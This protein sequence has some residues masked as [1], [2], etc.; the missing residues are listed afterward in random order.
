M[1]IDVVVLWVNGADPAW[2]EEKRKYAPPF[3]ISI[4]I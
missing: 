3:H 1:D 2:V 4:D